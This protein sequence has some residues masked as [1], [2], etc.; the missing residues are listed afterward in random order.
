MC[1]H[2]Y[3]YEVKYTDQPL[4]EPAD[5]EF[6]MRFLQTYYYSAKLALRCMADGIPM[7]SRFGTQLR[8]I[9]P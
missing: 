9:R 2:R 6:V 7:T 3:S 4:W 5:R 1:K 8:I